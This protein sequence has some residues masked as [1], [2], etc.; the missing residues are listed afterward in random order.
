MTSKRKYD[1]QSQE[2]HIPTVKEKHVKGLGRC[3]K[4]GLTDTYKEVEVYH[5]AQKGL[6]SIDKARLGGKFEVWYLEYEFYPTLLWPL[7]IYEVAVT[8]VER[9]EQQ[10]S[11]YIRKW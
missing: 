1:L 9:I 10:C 11:V 5:Q 4:D 3:Y 2:K 8:R 7:T 6:R